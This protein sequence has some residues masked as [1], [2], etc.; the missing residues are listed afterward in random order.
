MPQVFAKGREDGQILNINSAVLNTVA[1][2]SKDKVQQII[3]LSFEAS[4]IY[5][6]CL[7]QNPELTV[8]SDQASFERFLTNMLN[9]LTDNK[10]MMKTMK[11]Y[12][13]LYEVPQLDGA[14]LTTF[15]FKQASF[16]N[17]SNVNSI[18]H[19]SYRLRIVQL[20]LND[21]DNMYTE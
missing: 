19:L 16:I 17:K 2:I 11:L 5:I 6:E 7:K 15:L 20:L 14:Y 21:K 8:K 4:E 3:M 10:L 9:R 1:E 12:M 18:Q 13:Y